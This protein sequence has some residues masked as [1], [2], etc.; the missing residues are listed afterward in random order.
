MPRGRLAAS[1]LT[2]MQ[3]ILE[4]PND[5]AQ[6]LGAE[7]DVPHRV[8]EAVA[9]EGYRA[10]RLSRGQISSM[11]GLGFSETEAFLAANEAYLEYSTAD[12]EADRATLDRILAK[13]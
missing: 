7:A 3:V 11:L 6:Q 4:L 1:I 8:L 5:V 9:L 12:L 10:G 2:S 13:P